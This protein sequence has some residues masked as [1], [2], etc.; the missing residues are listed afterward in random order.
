[1]QESAVLWNTEGAGEIVF[2][3]ENEVEIS[4]VRKT[5]ELNNVLQMS[6]LEGEPNWNRVMMRSRHV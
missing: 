5:D 6:S 1:M 4:V 3:E 2:S